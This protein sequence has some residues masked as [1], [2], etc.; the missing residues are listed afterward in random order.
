MLALAPGGGGWCFC[1]CTHLHL[2]AHTHVQTHILHLIKD[3][4]LIVIELLDDYL[5]CFIVGTDNVRSKLICVFL[6]DSYG[7]DGFLEN[8]LA[9]EKW[10]PVSGCVGLCSP[11]RISLRSRTRCCLVRCQLLLVL[12]P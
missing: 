4:S 6:R 2:C 9:L 8:S 11:R 10:L 1:L 7:A 5:K 3:K 12:M